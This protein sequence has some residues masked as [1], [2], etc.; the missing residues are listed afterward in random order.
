MAKFRIKYALGGGFGG[1]R[2]KDWETVEAENEEEAN[3]IAR[4]SAIDEYERYSGMYGLRS[5]DQIM[6]E[7]DV[8]EEVAIEI[9]EEERESWLDYKVEKLAWHEGES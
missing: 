4:E 2:N 1:T 5:V 8:D 7:D 6:E 3:E 9:Y